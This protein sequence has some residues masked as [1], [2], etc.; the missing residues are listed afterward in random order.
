MAIL[1]DWLSFTI[2]IHTPPQGSSSP[3]C[4]WLSYLLE[5]APQV[6]TLIA[7]SASEATYLFALTTS[8]SSYISVSHRVRQRRALFLRSASLPYLSL[9]VQ[10][11]NP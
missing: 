4:D 10:L 3:R 6:N 7:S 9:R 11:R 2:H 1:T 5:P 8:S